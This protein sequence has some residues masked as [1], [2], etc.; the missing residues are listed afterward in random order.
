MYDSTPDALHV[1]Q[2]N[3][4]LWV[5][6][7]RPTINYA[8]LEALTTCILEATHDDQVRVLIV[9]VSADGDDG[10]DEEWRISRTAWKGTGGWR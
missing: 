9:N 7:L 6:F 3:T 4:Q 2:H 10:D 5:R 8:M 1:E